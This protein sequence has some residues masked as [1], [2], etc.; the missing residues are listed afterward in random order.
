MQKGKE[1][2]LS[3]G[4]T[5]DFNMIFYVD[6]LFYTNEDVKKNNWL[7][8]FGNDGLSISKVTSLNVNLY[9]SATLPSATLV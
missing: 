2:P 8:K 7:R 5:S 3:P 6:W 1:S 9:L 4:F